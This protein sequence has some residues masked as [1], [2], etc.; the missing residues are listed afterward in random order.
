MKYRLPLLASACAVALTLSFGAAKAEV[1]P[2]DL[3]QPIAD[4]KVYVQE[5]LDILVKDTKAFTDA[6]KAGDLE[7]AKELYP[8][9]RVS[10]EKIEPIAE[11]FA[12]LDAS[13]DSRAD[14]HENG[15]KS[16]DFTGFHRI[17]YGLFAQ[18]STEGLAP[19]ADRLYADVLEL[20]KRVKDLTV[21]PEKVV[22]GAAALLEEVAATKIS[23]EEDRYSHTDLWDFKA[24]VDGAQKIV[25][26]F[27]PLLEKEN[28][29]LVKKVEANF[30]TVDDILAKYKKGDGYE[31]YDKL[32]DDDRKALAGPVTTL[33]ED[34]S[35]LRGT[36]GLN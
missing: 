16:E 33:A 26:L 25:E 27:K 1:S 21:P 30:K 23:G 24:N 36:L 6:V 12:D 35:T 2:L 19:V 11:L 29:D 8:S 34:L 28:P 3:V 20:Q 14:D 22:G 17:E 4:Y 7:K 9:S 15:E 32:S 31:S 5:N 13:I 18:N 10:Y